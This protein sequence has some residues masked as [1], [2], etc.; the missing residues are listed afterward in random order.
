MGALG[1]SVEELLP[2][3][4]GGGPLKMALSV[5]RE[6]EWLQPEPDL[7]TR[8]AGFDAYPESVQLL[9][10]AEAAARELAALLGVA[11]GLEQAARSVWED[12]CVLVRREG[13]EVYRLVGTAVAFPTDWRPADKLGLPLIALH[14]PIHGYEEQ[15][16]TGVD[17]F[18]S[19]LHPGKAFGRCNW[20]VSPTGALRWVAAPPEQSFA[21]VTAENAG[22]TLFVRSERQALRKLPGTGAVVFTIGVYVTPLGSLS[23]GNVR[24]IAEAVATIP[25]EEA[26][27]RGARYFAPA[28]QGYAAGHGGAIDV[29]A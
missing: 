27:R 20:F 15:L 28:L 13:E 14:K 7:A 25:S 4:R 5:L 19:K 24:R 9:P 10:E 23:P 3:A 18:M 8:A 26:E 17:Q 12:L 29:A 1:F 2:R 21:H 22:D 11:G 16:A 6:D